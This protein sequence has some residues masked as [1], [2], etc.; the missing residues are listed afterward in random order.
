VRI[1]L[2]RRLKDSTIGTV[3][4]RLEE[5]G[6]MWHTV[7]ARTYVCQATESRG[8]VTAKAVRRIVKLVLRRFGRRGPGGATLIVIAAID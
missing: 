4:R 5:K 6:Y 2:K 1:A 7:D 3:L 8:E